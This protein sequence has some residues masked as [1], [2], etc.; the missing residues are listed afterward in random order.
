MGSIVGMKSGFLEIWKPLWL[1]ERWASAAALNAI[2][3]MSS[4]EV[5]KLYLLEF[6]SNNFLNYDIP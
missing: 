5:S 1:I 3:S 6:S 4:A 2:A